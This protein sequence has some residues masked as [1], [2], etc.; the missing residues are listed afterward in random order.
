M[1]SSQV[2]LFLSTEQYDP[3]SM[4]IRF[5]TECAWS[6]VGFYRLSDSYTFSAMSDGKGV[7]WRP[8]NP[9]AQILLLDD[10][11]GSRDGADV[12]EGA[13]A[14]AETK[15]GE[16]YDFLDILGITFGPNWETPGRLICDKLVLWA[17]QS[18]HFPL[19][20]PTFIPSS[21]FTPRDILLSP[22]LVERARS[23]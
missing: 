8:P 1:P 15:A 18:I 20:N 22:Y 14:A 11:R 3:V 4:A 9:R 7:A 12:M 13:L 2:C 5:K 6:H 10:T 16:G 21:H 17:F 23:G 19:L